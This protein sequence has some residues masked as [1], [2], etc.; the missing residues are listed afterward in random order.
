VDKCNVDICLTNYSKTA[1]HTE[2]IYSFYLL[3]KWSVKIKRVNI[4]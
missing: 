4:F 1:R 3:Q 2:S